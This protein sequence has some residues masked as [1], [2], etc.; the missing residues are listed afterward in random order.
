MNPEL[1]SDAQ[2]FAQVDFPAGFWALTAHRISVEVG[3]F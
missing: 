2:W 1:S 3:V